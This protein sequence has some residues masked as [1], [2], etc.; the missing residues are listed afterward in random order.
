MASRDD[1]EAIEAFVTDLSVD[2]FEHVIDIDGVVWQHFGVVSQP[3]F[4]FINDDG[5][6]ETRIGAM[7]EDGLREAIEQLT[8]T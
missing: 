5:T 3:A 6:V 7:G 2:G 1:V 4:S 8:S